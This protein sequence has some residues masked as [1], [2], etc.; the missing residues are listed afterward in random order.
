[1]S[2]PLRLEAPEVEA[3]AREAGFDL[4]GFAPAR[5]L[6]R[7]PLLKWL[8]AGHHAD[9]GWMAEHVEERLDVTRLFPP[10]RTVVALACNYWQPGP[11]DA[12]IARYARGR[13]YHATLRDR[14]RGLRRRLRARWPTLTDYG[15]VDANPVMEKV[16][17]TLAGL[18]AIG[19]NGCLITRE[20]GSWV[21]LAVLIIDADVEAPPAEPMRVCGACRRCLDACPT[22]A[23]PGDGVVDSRRCLSYQTIENE[24]P[25]PA[26]LRPAMAEVVFGCDACQTV[27]PHNGR[28]RPGSSRF[29]PRDIA[30]L[31]ARALAGLSPAE[32]TSL[33]PGTALM[34]AGYD[35]VRRN[36]AYALGAARDL[37]ARELLTTLT[38]DPAEAV[39]EAARWALTKLDEGGEASEGLRST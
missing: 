27:C 5:A 38:A 7:G 11:D 19:K 14:L 17:A 15:S 33:A 34:R 21:V 39:R 35:G 2:S 28:G 25:V 24:Q 16:W 26:P 23:L 10:A 18:G 8:D 37:E 3:L 1:M 20:F 6:P 13:D 9:L 32:W 29:E 22:Q 36:A 30:S 4:V 31:T 12:P